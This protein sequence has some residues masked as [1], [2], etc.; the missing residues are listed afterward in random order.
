MI[1][2][3]LICCR[4]L[5]GFSLT[6][7]RTK[8]L[9]PFGPYRQDCDKPSTVEMSTERDPIPS[10]RLMTPLLSDDSPILSP[11]SFSLPGT[12]FIH[13]LLEEVGSSTSPP[14]S[15]I[16]NGPSTTTNVYAP[17]PSF[18]DGDLT[19]I[20]ASGL[21]LTVRDPMSADVQ[22]AGAN[23]SVPV[24]AGLTGNP[25]KEVAVT[26]VAV[27]PALP[28]VARVAAPAA[29][30]GC[31]LA[32][33]APEHPSPETG[34]QDEHDEDPATNPAVQGTATADSSEAKISFE[35]PEQRPRKRGDIQ[36]NP[37]SKLIEIKCKKNI[38]LK[39][40]LP[41]NSAIDLHLTRMSVYETEPI[42][43]EDGTPPFETHPSPTMVY[44]DNI[45]HTHL[46][47]KCGKDGR[48]VLRF[49]F[50]T[51][52]CNPIAGLSTHPEAARPWRLVVQSMEGPDLPSASICLQVFSMLRNVMRPMYRVTGNTRNSEVAP[53]RLRR[54]MDDFRELPVDL[55][56]HHLHLVALS[57]RAVKAIRE[58]Q[59][60]NQPDA[61]NTPSTQ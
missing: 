49:P 20:C 56:E 52:Q 39:T 41:E 31:Q 48:V 23:S 42:M 45:G 57:L 36:L 38:I 55:Q 58:H 1:L 37:Q 8:A 43:R 30:T 47:T 59:A 16:S 25:A 6:F 33:R 44:Q 13:D 29:T 27:I 22:P 7:Q 46:R 50:T 17:T 54:L 10:P 28:G 5:N 9:R 24:P 61:T 40:W 4:P 34:S 12:P 2:R 32:V 35:I 19:T 15:T 11:P 53:P 14:P 60:N 26:T 51:V 3:P 21:P 18:S